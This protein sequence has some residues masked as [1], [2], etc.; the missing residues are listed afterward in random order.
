MTK[1][2]SAEPTTRAQAGGLVIGQNMFR[3]LENL[4]FVIVSDFEIRA[5][6]LKC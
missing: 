1:I 5:S 2:G 4:D 6:N 3:K